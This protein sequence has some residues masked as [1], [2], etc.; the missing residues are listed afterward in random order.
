MTTRSSGSLDRTA[1]LIIVGVF[2]ALVID[3]MDLQILALALPTL[4]RELQL[5]NVSAG[6]LATA[7]G[8]CGGPC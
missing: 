3:G 7:C 2:V 6:A 5:S 1:T 4:S 8:W